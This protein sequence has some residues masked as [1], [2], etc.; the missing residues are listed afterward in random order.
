MLEKQFTAH[1]KRSVV[2]FLSFCPVSKSM[3]LLHWNAD[4]NDSPIQVFV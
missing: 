3:P 1:T 4:A 2:F